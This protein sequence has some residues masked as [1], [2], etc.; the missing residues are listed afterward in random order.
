MKT[1]EFSFSSNT[2]DFI[3]SYSKYVGPYLLVIIALFIQ[4]LQIGFRYKLEAALLLVSGSVVFIILAG[5]YLYH[6]YKNIKY[7]V[8]PDL[9]Q[10]FDHTRGKVID[11]LFSDLEEVKFPGIKDKK[12]MGKQSFYLKF[13][14]KKKLVFS[15]ILPYYGEIRDFMAEILEEKGYQLSK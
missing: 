5:I 14:H 2:F 12:K 3:K 15:S 11:Y 13:K 4:F 6:K 10:V 1:K 9:I 8:S 7:I